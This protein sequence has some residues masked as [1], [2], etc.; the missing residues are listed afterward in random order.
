MGL[1]ENS[2]LNI[3]TRKLLRHWSTEELLSMYGLNKTTKAAHTSIILDV[4]Q[5]I[6]PMAYI[7]AE[8]ILGSLSKTSI[9]IKYI[10]LPRKN[11]H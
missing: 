4:S 8:L 10:T 1:N 6:A 9:A 3:N 5:I 7:L 2:D 11:L